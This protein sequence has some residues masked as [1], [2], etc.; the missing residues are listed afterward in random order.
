ML[1]WGLS[2]CGKTTTLCKIADYY[3][4]DLKYRII[5]CHTPSDIF[6]LQCVTEKIIFVIDDIFG[7]FVFSYE[8]FLILK[9]L[10]K[11][12]QTFIQENT[13]KLLMTCSSVA[14]RT[15]FVH[16]LA[17]F[18]NNTFE[19]TET[20]LLQNNKDMSAS[21][22]R[23]KVEQLRQSNYE[24]WCCLFILILKQGCIHEADL[25]T[26]D[27]TIFN[28]LIDSVSNK[29][30]IEMSGQQFGKNLNTLMDTFIKKENR[31]FSIIQTSVFE[32]LA[33]YFGEEFQQV[34][35][36]FADPE[37]ITQHCCLTSCPEFKGN[38]TFRIQ[39]NE[40]NEGLY[41][42]KIKDK[43]QRKFLTE[44][45]SVQQMESKS[46]REKL[47][48]FIKGLACLD[49][50]L[51]KDI[52]TSTCRIKIETALT[53]TAGKYVKLSNTFFEAKK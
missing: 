52:H 17:L 53:L 38:G 40:E 23:N 11:T 28:K 5:T 49:P 21:E 44:V 30:N 43:L 14:F 6:S 36:Q 32:V 26:D 19:L 42:L 1:L 39:V 27:D 16:E 50:D 48:V 34:L 31:L 24:A 47:D 13:V 18:S 8:K 3:Q 22:I 51:F 15:D 7:R 35:L 41:F 10:E 37:L 29:L 45:F 4:K 25:T 46:Y 20:S 12:I 9:E 2:G 33:V